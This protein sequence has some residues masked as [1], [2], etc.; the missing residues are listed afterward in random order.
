MF[1]KGKSLFCAS[2]CCPFTLARSIYEWIACELE[3]HTNSMMMHREAKK[4]TKLSRE[5]SLSQVVTKILFQV[6]KLLLLVIPYRAFFFGSFVCA[7]EKKET[8]SAN[9]V[10]NTCKIRRGNEMTSY[11]ENTVFLEIK[12]FS[13]PHRV[14]WKQNI[15]S[16][17]LSTHQVFL[18]PI[19]FVCSGAVR[20][21]KEKSVHSQSH[22]TSLLLN[23]CLNVCTLTLTNPKINEGVRNM[24][25][26]VIAR[27]GVR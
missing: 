20:R 25:S 21:T 5:K 13:L 1:E 12:I 26:R 23:H 18:A 9:Q 3:L 6:P 15:F 24:R 19:S 7:R 22:R 14:C 8:P 17:C 16:R 4:S 2:E 11:V 27:N 10:Q